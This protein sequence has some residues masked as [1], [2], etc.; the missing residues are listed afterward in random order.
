MFSL[1]QGS[2]P[3]PACCPVDEL[4]VWYILS[5]FLVF[6]KWQKTSLITV[7]L[8]Q[9]DVDIL[10]NAKKIENMSYGAFALTSQPLTVAL[11]VNI[12]QWLTAQITEP[13]S[14][15]EFKS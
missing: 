13:A 2:Q 3:S 12:A 15:T 4:V 5:S 7:S 1:S 6:F 14:I 9:P 11:L 8:L 10:T